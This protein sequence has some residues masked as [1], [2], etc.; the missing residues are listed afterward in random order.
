MLYS[1]LFNNPTLLAAL[2][3]LPAAIFVADSQGHVIWNNKRSEEGIGIPRE[4]IK[5]KHVTELEKSNILNPSLTRLVL[6]KRSPVTRVQELNANVKRVTVSGP[7]Y[8]EDG[9]I[10]IVISVSH[11]LDEIDQNGDRM[12][13]LKELLQTYMCQ[14][15]QVYSLESK[16]VA[17][18][19]I[20]GNSKAVEHLKYSI[21]RVS[22]LSSTVLLTGETGVGKSFVAQVIHQLSNRS[23]GPYLSLNCGTIPESLLE[24]ELFGYVK[25]AFTGA[26]QAGKSGLVETAEGGTLFLDEIGELPYTMQVKLLELLEDKTFMPI[27]GTKKKAADIRIIAATNQPL[28][29]MV[30]EKHFR[31]DLYYRLNVFGINIPPLRERK[32]DVSTLAYIFL[33]QYNKE[34]GKFISLSSEAV[35]L[36]TQYKWPG[37]IR[38]LENVIERTVVFSPEE[39][40]RPK[41]LPGF[42]QKETLLPENMIFQKNS[43]ETLYDFLERV[44]KDIIFLTAEQ[45]PNTREIAKNLGMTQPTLIRRMKKYRKSGHNE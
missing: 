17:E 1:Q 11:S 24:S 14:L 29:K 23:S 15:Q 20:T 33:H 28:E 27:G 21:Q 39:V 40:V 8:N 6:E 44:E 35:D 26:S 22:D 16:S 45:H 7:I 36:L 31:S 13:E 25:G 10:D 4:K 12:D 30:E 43:D 34:Y 18:R 38:E 32:E 2:D 5:G 19:T 9:E 3:Q 42:I 41:H 37:N